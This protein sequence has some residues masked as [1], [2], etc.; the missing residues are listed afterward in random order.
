M[1]VDIF[2]GILQKFLKQ[3]IVACLFQTIHL[4]WI[5]LPKTI[6]ILNRNGHDNILH[7]KNELLL[8][9]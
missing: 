6:I 4:A 1:S 3:Q 2:I 7:V 8:R 5:Y 9:R